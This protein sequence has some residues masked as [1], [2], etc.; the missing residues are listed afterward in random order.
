LLVCGVAWY[1]SPHN[2]QVICIA[3]FETTFFSVFL[4]RLKVKQLGQREPEAELCFTRSG[5]EE[6]VGIMSV[7]MRV[8]S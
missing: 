4:N 8:D 2:T 5:D 1:S 6:P 7:K 3:V